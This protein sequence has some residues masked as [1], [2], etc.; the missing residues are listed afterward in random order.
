MRRDL[1][2]ALDKA[3]GNEQNYARALDGEGGTVEA[4]SP[5]SSG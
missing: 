3:A 5:V 1:L 4:A 2:T